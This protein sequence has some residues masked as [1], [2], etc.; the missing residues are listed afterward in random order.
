MLE[1]R[2]WSQSME[3]YIEAPLAGHLTFLKNDDVPGVI[4]HV[5]AVL[6]RNG[7]NIA[8]FSLGRQETPVGSDHPL[9]SRFGGRNRSVSARQVWSKS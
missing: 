6:G 4:G 7:I 8:N 3:F 9:R 5:G 2:V 1:S